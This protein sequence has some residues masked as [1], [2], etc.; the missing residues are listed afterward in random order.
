MAFSIY[1]YLEIKSGHKKTDFKNRYIYKNGSVV[2]LVWSAHYL[3]AEQ[4]MFAI[5]R[6]ASEIEK[7]KEQLN[8]NQRR[9]E[10]MVKSGNDI[11]CIIG[12]DGTYKYVSPSV[13]N[14]YTTSQNFL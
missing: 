12:A 10:A 5:A 1:T 14:I 13:R 6:D 2:P 9:L 11:I 3:P 8:L 4:L 7:Q